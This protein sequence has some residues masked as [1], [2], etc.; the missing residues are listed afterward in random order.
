MIKSTEN[1]SESVSGDEKRQSISHE[2]LTRSGDWISIWELAQRNWPQKP[3]YYAS[4]LL[5]YSI[6][7]DL[8][9][10]VG[11]IIEAIGGDTARLY[12]I[13]VN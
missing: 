2:D 12:N 5:N 1:E 4:R 9:R 7:H 11:E 10:V 3:R 13:S 6:L 8:P